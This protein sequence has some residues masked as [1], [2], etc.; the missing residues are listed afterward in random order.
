[1][2][3]THRGACLS[4]TALEVGLDSLQLIGAVALHPVVGSFAGLVGEVQVLGPVRLPLLT[5][6]F[7]QLITLGDHE[8][9]CCTISSEGHH[10]LWWSCTTA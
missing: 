8:G 10:Q 4:L 6:G 9:V 2:P 5:V 7:V 1:V 3:C